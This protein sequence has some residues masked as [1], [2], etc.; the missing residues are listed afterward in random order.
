M[1]LFFFFANAEMTEHDIGSLVALTQEIFQAV[2]RELK[3]PAFGKAFQP[4]TS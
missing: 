3:L 4:G 1:L 2:E